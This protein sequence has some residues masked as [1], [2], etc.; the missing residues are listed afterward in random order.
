MLAYH[1]DLLEQAEH[2]A[3]R[4]PQKPKQASL[5]RAVSTAYYAL[6]HLLIA[7]G[8]RLLFPR[9]PPGLRPRIARA[10]AHNAMRNVCKGFIEANVA[11]ARGRPSDGIPNATRV[12]LVFPLVPALVAVL[13]AVVEIQEA[14]HEADYDLAKPW[15]RLRAA[16]HVATARNAFASWQAIRHDLNTSVL[17][18]A[19]LLRGQWGR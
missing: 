4:E 2:L 10:F 3:A 18:A 11:A 13:E 9:Q 5:R 19:I 1:H 6:F 14:P 17:V 8:P 15:N 7:D 16:N 12:L